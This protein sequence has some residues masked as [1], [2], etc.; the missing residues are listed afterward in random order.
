MW[1]MLSQLYTLVKLAKS[2]YLFLSFVCILYIVFVCLFKLFVCIFNFLLPLVENKDVQFF[3]QL[4]TVPPAPVCQSHRR[5][6]SLVRNL[7]MGGLK[8]SQNKKRLAPPFCVMHHG[9]MDHR[10]RRV[11]NILGDIPRT[12][13]LPRLSLEKIPWGNSRG[14]VRVRTQ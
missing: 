8:T 3:L 13:T 1:W 2:H 14:S 4:E 10:P 7:V 6:R 12:H 9:P 11:L 5:G